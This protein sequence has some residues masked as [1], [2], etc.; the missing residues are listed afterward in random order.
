MLPTAGR[1]GDNNEHEEGVLGEVA[2]LIECTGVNT[3]LDQQRV[4][5]FA[6]EIVESGLAQDAVLSLNSEQEQESN[7]ALLFYIPSSL[8]VY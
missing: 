1:V 2:V 3:E 5:A 8:F 6:E 7:I 4:D